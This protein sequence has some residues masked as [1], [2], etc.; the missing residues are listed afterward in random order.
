MSQMKIDTLKRSAAGISFCLVAFLSLPLWTMSLNSDRL[1][2]NQL[3]TANSGLSYN[4]V[5]SIIQ[6]SIG[7]IWV[8]TADGLNRYDGTK[9]RTFR[10]DETGINSDFIT[11]L[12]EDSKHNIWVGTDSGVTIYE[13]KSGRFKPFNMLSDQQTAI[14]NKVSMIES[15]REGNIWLAVN[16]QGLFSYN[17]KT[18]VLRNFFVEGGEQTLPSS[19]S[20]FYFDRDNVC[21]LAL[22]YANLY[23]ADKDFK[24]VKPVNFG[25]KGQFFRNDNIASIIESPTNT[26]YVASAGKG[27]C[28]IPPQRDKVKVLISSR[29]SRFL[30]EAMLL[31]KNRELWMSTSR[32]V[33]V[34]N[35]VTGQYRY[36]SADNNDRFSLSNKH[37]YSICIDNADGIWIGAHTGGVNYSGKFYENFDRYYSVQGKPLYDCRVRG[38]SEDEEGQLWITTDNEGLLIYDLNTKELKKYENKL[39]TEAYHR[40]CYDDGKLW[41]GSISGLYQLDVHSGNVKVFSQLDNVTSLRSDNISILYKTKQGN[42]LIGTTLGMFQYKHANNR[43][44]PVPGF[45]G[46]FITDMIEDSRGNLWV[47]TWNDG[48]IRYDLGQNKILKIYKNISSDPNSLPINKILSVFEDKIGR[49]WITTAGAGFCLYDELND[50]FLIYN[51]FTLNRSMSDICYKIIEGDN[52]LWIPSSHG[53]ISFTPETTEMMVYTMSD[54]LLNNEFENL[55]GYKSKNGTIFFGSDDGFITFNPQKF[56]TD[57]KIPNIVITDFYIDEKIV[58]IG[59]KGSPLR[60]IINDT[61]NISLSAKQNSFGFGFAL[62]GFT[63]PANNEILC[64]LEGFDT[65][66]QNISVNNTM[67]YSNIPAGKYQLLVKGKGSNSKWNEQRAPITITIAQKFYKSTIAILL[68]IFVLGCTISFFFLYSFKKAVRREQAKQEEYKR[69]HEAQLFNEKMTFFSNVIHEIKTPLTLIHTPMQNIL[70]LKG[71]DETIKDELKVINNSAEY[72]SKL[73]NELL[74]FVKL[75]RRGYTL[76]KQ[77]IDLTEKIGLLCFN[78]SETAKSNGIRLRLI[79]HDEHIYINADESGLTKILNNLIHNAL[80]FAKSYIEIKVKLDGGYVSVSFKNDGPIIPERHRY[81][82]FKPFIRLESDTRSYFKGVG[83]GLPLARKIAELHSGS[84]ILDDQEN[85]TNFIL[86]LPIKS[87]IEDTIDENDMQDLAGDNQRYHR[88]LVVEDNT[89]LSD[90]LKHKLQSEYRILTASNTEKALELLK[91]YHVDLVV[92]D[93]VLDQSD[94]LELCRIVNSEIEFSHIPVIILSARSSEKSKIVGMESGANLYIEKPF[95]LEYLQAC[96]K[97]LLNKRVMR[98]TAIMNKAITLPQQFVNEP[99]SDEKFL[100][101]LDS[102]IMENIS[103][104][105]FSNE[106]LAEALYLSKSTLTRKIKGLLDTTPHDYIRNMRLVIAAKMMSEKHY[107]INDICYSVGFNTPSYFAKCFKKYYGVLP[108]EY[109]QEHTSGPKETNYSDSS[110]N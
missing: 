72:M 31:D 1:Y 76:N 16:N 17:P 78:F 12:F 96:I 40:I 94:G 77:E 43:F 71:G 57:T 70:A 50:N 83:I 99:Y 30:P 107:R 73:V 59:D 5:Y 105:D 60:F 35:T 104:P 41:L 89:D 53:L 29:E 6:D 21:W 88:L 18:G 108:S 82:I 67:F 26:L 91:Q 100:R 54:G 33:Y 84:L 2:F 52:K 80:K 93:V 97:N 85:C 46:T 22:Y 95:N 64:K 7:F 92:T 15:D 55:A 86:T 9:F 58:Q 90:Y 79:H 36:F 81:N 13:I 56:Y 37:V 61:Q 51:H 39:L 42:M 44:I 101:M 34:Y 8:G 38:F 23:R 69:T 68:Y 19:I 109:T 110:H 25:E 45:D 47:S 24:S 4:R 66:W 27:L 3:N 103:D 11:Y 98:K 63:S 10:K 102:I 28:E 20:T 87:T 75:E 48:L 65:E 14:K 49:I 74:D 62:L 106:Q 32:G